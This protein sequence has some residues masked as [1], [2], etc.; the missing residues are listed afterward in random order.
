[1]GLFT[2]ARNIPG[3]YNAN[4]VEVNSL[5]LCVNSKFGENFDLIMA[6][7]FEAT[8]FFG[9]YNPPPLGTQGDQKWTISTKTAKEQPKDDLM[10]CPHFP[11][12]LQSSIFTNPFRAIMRTYNNMETYVHTNKTG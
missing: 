3:I 11:K 6:A 7:I 4:F 8:K 5:R 9:G 12:F 10:N 1:M 2:K